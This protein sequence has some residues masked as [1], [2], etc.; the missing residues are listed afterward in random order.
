MRKYR[1]LWQSSTAISGMP[2]Y[3]KAIEDHGKK[4]LSPNFELTVRGVKSGTSHLHFM[5]FDFLNNWQ[6]FDSVTQAEKEGYDAVAIGCFFDPILDEL[7]EV[8]NIPVM[9]LAE[10]GMLT[11]CML[12]KY[13]SVVSYVPQNNNKLIAEVLH[14]IGLTHRATPFTSFDLPLN[15]LEK[16]FKNPKPVLDRFEAAAGEAVG[17]GAEVILPGCGCLNLVIVNGGMHQVNGATVLDVSGAL[18]KLTEMMIVLKEVSGTK[19]SRKGYYEA[20]T[21]EQLTEVLKIY[22]KH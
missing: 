18:M 3:K 4:I 5:A 17:K 6:L 7:R 22:G 20:P 21:P 19:V 12:G 13:F 14:K 16:G 10:A 9:S 2:D 15:E 11:A 8:M 1:I